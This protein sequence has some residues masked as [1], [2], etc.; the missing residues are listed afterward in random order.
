MIGHEVL[1]DA[2]MDAREAAARGLGALVLA[3][4][5]VHVRGGPAEIGE[6][7][8]EA[9]GARELAHLAKDAPLAPALDDT[10]FVLGDA[11]EGAASE[12]ATH[13]HDRVLHRLERRDPFIRI[14][15]VRRTRERQI[16]EAVHLLFRERKRGRVEVDRLVAV[17][18]Q[19]RAAVVRVGLVLER[20]AHPRERLLV[21]RDLLVGRKHDR[22][23]IGHEAARVRRDRLPGAAVLLHVGGAADVGEGLDLLTGV[24]AAR[25]LPC[26]ALAHAED[27]EVG[28]RV[29]QDRSADLIGPVV[30]VRDPPERG[31]DATEH[32]RYT[33]EGLTAEVRVDDGR[34]VRAEVRTAA[35]R[36]LVLR[37]DL[38]LRRQLVE[39]RVE[40]ARA[41]TD[42]QAR[43]PHP[44]D[45]RGRVPA[46]LGD[47]ADPVAAP[48]EEAGHEDRP[49][50]GVIHVGVTRHDQDVELVPAARLHLLPRGRE[51]TRTAQLATGALMT[52]RLLADLDEVRHAMKGGCSRAAHHAAKRGRRPPLLFEP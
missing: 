8:G 17:R 52:T 13:R 4:H 46:G 2:G 37:A 28:L 48:L 44:G 18:L 19:D 49:E 41:D 32:D 50:R 6:H 14:G 30:V 38:L 9:G 34:A 20:A 26:G 23:P 42:E 16:V 12:A 35:G 47:D 31:L 39:H 43:P 36:I 29:E 45:V 22:L 33:G 1:A 51:E 24:E 10:S 5:L 40:V 3:R 21:L 11:A 15:R 25:D 27:E 7:A